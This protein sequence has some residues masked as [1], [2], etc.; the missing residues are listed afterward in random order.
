MQ[1]V[2]GAWAVALQSWCKGSSGAFPG[3]F[4]ILGA[5]DTLELLDFQLSE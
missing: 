1:G 2:I 5:A 3:D 4:S